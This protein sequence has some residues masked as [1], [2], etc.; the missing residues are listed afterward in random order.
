MKWKINAENAQGRVVTLFRY[1]ICYH[2]FGNPSFSH[3]KVRLQLSARCQ[4]V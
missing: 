3:I 1:R 2:P 4:C